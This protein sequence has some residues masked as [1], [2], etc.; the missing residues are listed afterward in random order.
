[1]LPSP[2]LGPPLLSASPSPPPPC[3]MPDGAASAGALDVCVT[4][5]GAAS[6][7]EPVG[8]GL[9]CVVDVRLVAGAEAFGAALGT[10]ACV[11]VCTAGEAGMCASV[12]GADA[13]PEAEPAEDVPAPLA[14]VCRCA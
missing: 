3:G 9:A 7:R 14:E 12:A 1:M 10:A 11:L 8:A 5:G 13:E 4:G 2:S 6:V